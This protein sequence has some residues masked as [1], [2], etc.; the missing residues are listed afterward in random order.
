MN[1]GRLWWSWTHGRGFEH[2]AATVETSGRAEG[3][4]GGGAAAALSSGLASTVAMVKLGLGFEGE[5]SSLMIV[6][7]VVGLVVRRGGERAVP[8]GAEPSGRKKLHML[9]HVAIG[10]RNHRERWGHVIPLM[11][12]GPYVMWRA[13]IN[14]IKLK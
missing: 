4:A 11:R 9:V 2:G 12:N 14:K 3:G 6:E 5:D 13:C 7:V 10:E 8:E 1:G